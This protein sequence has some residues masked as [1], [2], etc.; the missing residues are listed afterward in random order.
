MLRTQIY[1]TDEEVSG[2]SALA[3][4]SGKKQS[5]L[6]REAIDSYLDSKASDARLSALRACA[7]IWKDRADLPDFEALRATFNRSTQ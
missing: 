5:E 6:I 3:A 2:I 4:I 1:L 7:G